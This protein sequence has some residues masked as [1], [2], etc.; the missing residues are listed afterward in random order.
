MAR[1]RPNPLFLSLAMLPL[2][3]GQAEA[4]VR[5]ERD[6]GAGRAFDARL[7][8]QLH[9]LIAACWLPPLAAQDIGAVRLRIALRPDGS[10]D[11]DPV[12]LDARDD[13]A[14]RTLADSALRAVKRCA[15]FAALAQ[16]QKHYERWRTIVLNFRAPH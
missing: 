11:G 4:L 13:P 5:R 14:F 7:A 8:R 2:L 9:G 12:V 15:P 1:H 3:A 10:L 6:D 16:E